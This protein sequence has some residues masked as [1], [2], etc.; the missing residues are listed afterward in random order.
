ME[1]LEGEEELEGKEELEGEEEWKVR[2]VRKSG[3]AGNVT[4]LKIKNELPRP[5]GS[6]YTH[7]PVSVNSFSFL[8]FLIHL[9]DYPVLIS[10]PGN[11]DRQ[12][13]LS[14]PRILAGHR[15]TLYYLN[16]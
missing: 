14:S 1:E 15:N 10:G 3:R 2:K 16:F 7:L 9:S 11:Q 8:K 6:V 5:C 13:T 4:A 12:L